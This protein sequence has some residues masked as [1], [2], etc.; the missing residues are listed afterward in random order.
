MTLTAYADK[1]KVR[2]YS[3]TTIR[4]LNVSFDL[5]NYNLY[6]DGDQLLEDMVG[7][8]RSVLI[9]PEGKQ[10]HVSVNET[11]YGTF[12]TLRLEATD[13][14]C[15]LCINP[16]GSKQRTYEGDLEVS[17]LKSGSLQLINNVEFETYIAG[18]VQS[19]I[20]GKRTDIFRIQAIISRTW[21]LRNM[22]KHRS[23]G[24]NFCD[25]VH[26]QAYHNRCIRPDI[27]MGAIQSSG[28][29]LVD[30]FGALI[31][32]PSTPTPAARPPTPR[33]YG[34]PPCPT[35]APL[36][37]H[38]LTTCVKAT[39]RRPSPSTAGSPTS[40][41]PTSW[42]PRTPPSATP[43]STSPRSTVACASSACR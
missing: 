25:H 5:G 32:T 10:L 22:G 7:E 6:A 30:Q 3:N 26:C 23:D 16:E 33:M 20:Y 17:L 43:S 8:G 40:P 11:D 28:E 19:E 31:E 35:S 18:V 9:R 36:Q 12:N 39:G 15:I 34:A 37:T 4:T 13:T 27:M 1:V 29:T 14:A 38:S 21:A 2:L 42:T 24:Y 41:R